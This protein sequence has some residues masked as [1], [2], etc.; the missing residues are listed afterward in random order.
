MTLRGAMALVM[1]G[2]LF[3]GAAPAQAQKLTREQEAVATRY[4]AL[5]FVDADMGLADLLNARMQVLC[6]K[7]NREQP[8]RCD[9]YPHVLHADVIDG[10]LAAIEIGLK[11]YEIGG[12]PEYRKQISRLKAQ[13]ELDIT[14]V[15]K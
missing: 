6:L 9:G 13:A 10:A 5:G 3:L 12:G 4:E 2:A 1:V 11:A 7:R 15:M 8:S 14:R